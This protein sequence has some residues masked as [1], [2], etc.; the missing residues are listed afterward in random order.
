MARRCSIEHPMAWAAKWRTTSEVA[1][2][3]QDWM[4]R[5]GMPTELTASTY[6]P[7][8]HDLYR[9]AEG[10]EGSSRLMRGAT[11]ST[12]TARE[13]GEPLTTNQ[14]DTTTRMTAVVEEQQ[15]MRKEQDVHNA[16]LELRTKEFEVENGWQLDGRDVPRAFRD[17]P[18]VHSPVGEARLLLER[19]DRESCIRYYQ[20]ANHAQDRD[21]KHPAYKASLETIIA[22]V[23]EREALQKG[24]RTVESTMWDNKRLAVRDPY[25]Y[26]TRPTSA[27]YTIHA[28][29]L[30]RRSVLRDTILS[31]GSNPAEAS[32]RAVY[33][34][35][36][37]YAPVGAS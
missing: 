5:T 30:D 31:L 1:G 37:K 24:G 8:H 12:Q 34:Y 21:A 36:G 13:A 11:L 10:V 9:V 32:N 14:S 27:P 23:T 4:E 15:R 6:M 28:P 16:A 3:R 18:K 26:G 33:P 25:A 29:Q 2:E 7:R 35:V 19:H 17:R 22:Q 20:H